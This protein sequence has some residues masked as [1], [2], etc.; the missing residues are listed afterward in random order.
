MAI[1]LKVTAEELRQA[2]GDF[3]QKNANIET[4][5]NNMLSL[6]TDISGDV[7]SGDAATAY[8]SKF[9]GLADDIGALCSD[10]KEK[11]A[12]LQEIAIEYERAENENLETANALN[13]NLIQ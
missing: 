12:D 7:W 3:D 9:A 4:I 10:L 6:I 1:Q 2:A 11:S 8:K 5:T 13:S